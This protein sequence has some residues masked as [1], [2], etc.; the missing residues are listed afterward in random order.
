MARPM[1]VVAHAVGWEKEGEEFL[2]GID[3]K[4]E[5]P[6]GRLEG[7]GDLKVSVFTSLDGYQAYYTPVSYPGYARWGN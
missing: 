6:R 7:L 3:A 2:K 1:R 5:E 4:M